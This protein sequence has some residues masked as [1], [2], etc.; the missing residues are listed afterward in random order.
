MSL[1]SGKLGKKEINH[2]SL[3]KD[4]TSI[5]NSSQNGKLQINFIL[6]KISQDNI[7]IKIVNKNIYPKAF[8]I[9]PKDNLLGLFRVFIQK[10]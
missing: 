3:G 7:G 4:K 8:A 6:C 1:K 2:K 5:L 9:W 10:I